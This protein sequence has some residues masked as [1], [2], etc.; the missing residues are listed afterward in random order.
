M[1]EQGSAT[2]E[3]ARNVQQAASGTREVSA[4]IIGV[5]QGANDTGE[6]A[7]RVLGA[8]GELSRQAD[9]LRTE[10]SQYIRGVKSA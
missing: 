5:S 6:A 4:N 9:Q 8:A 2:K 1:E 7:S 3:I 10:V